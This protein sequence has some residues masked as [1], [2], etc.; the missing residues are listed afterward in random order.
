MPAD[1]R[2]GRVFVD[3]DLLQTFG[4]NAGERRRLRT[5]RQE[6]WWDLIARPVTSVNVV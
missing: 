3:E 6:E 1:P 2:A 5:K 4:G